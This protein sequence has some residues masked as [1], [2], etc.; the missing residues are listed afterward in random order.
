[1]F[2]IE[3]LN[4]IEHTLP[5]LKPSP[6]EVVYEL[7]GKEKEVKITGGNIYSFRLEPVH[8]KDLKFLSIK[9]DVGISVRHTKPINLSQ[10]EPDS[11]ISI[12]REY[13]VNGQKTNIFNE[14]DI[15]EVR[16]YPSFSDKAMNGDYQITDI[17]PSGLMPITKL[18]QRGGR[19]DCHYWYPYNIDGQLVKYKINRYWHN[20]YCGGNFIRYYARVKNRGEYKAEPVIIQSFLNPDYINYSSTETINIGE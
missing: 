18:Y 19:Y 16:L 14:G 3:K 15:I 13:Y 4:Y 10:V 2:N 12:R 17:L 7:F 20:N 8:I 5:N 1:L 9:G 11:A 6:A